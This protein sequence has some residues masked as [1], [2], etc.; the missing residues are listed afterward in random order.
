MHETQNTHTYDVLEEIRR[1]NARRNKSE[2][3]EY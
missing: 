2:R 1:Q 3:T